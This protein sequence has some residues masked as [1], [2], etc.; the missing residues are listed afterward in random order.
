MLSTRLPEHLGRRPARR[1]GGEGDRVAA[2]PRDFS[3]VV[4]MAMFLEL[5]PRDRPGLA[6]ML[7]GG[8]GG[9][10]WPPATGRP[11]LA[12]AGICEGG[13]DDDGLA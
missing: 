7:G 5:Q 11:G 10:G 3:P 13:I 8:S 2:P 9:R 12:V 1:R 6:I 4:T